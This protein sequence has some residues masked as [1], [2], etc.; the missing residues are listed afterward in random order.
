MHPMRSDDDRDAAQTQR[1]P[2]TE[3]RPR[4]GIDAAPSD[5]IALSQRRDR[6]RCCPRVREFARLRSIE[7]RPDAQPVRLGGE[8]RM[9]EDADQA[10][11]TP[12]SQNSRSR[13]HAGHAASCELFQAAIVSGSS[14]DRHSPAS[15]QR[16]RGWWR[17]LR[18]RGRCDHASDGTG[19][20]S[21]P[22]P[23][24][25][26]CAAA[27]DRAER[28]TR[29]GADHATGDRALSRII[30]IAATRQTKAQHSDDYA[31]CEQSYGHRSPPFFGIAIAQRVSPKPAAAV[32]AFMRR[33]QPSS[34]GD[35]LRRRGVV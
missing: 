2:R 11:S 17:R 32:P 13:R 4:A 16:L 7:M 33:R 15:S 19:D 6:R 30:R 29:T 25:G 35:G 10:P 14:A 20:G 26:A 5:T 27:G 23:D 22:R 8:G 3:R 24:G 12:A 21:D 28:G 1:R 31:G 18:R 34:P 9:V